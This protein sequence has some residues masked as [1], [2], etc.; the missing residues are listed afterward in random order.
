MDTLIVDLDV[1]PRY[2]WK[3][4]LKNLEILR[5]TVL[6]ITLA[7]N[8]PDYLLDTMIPNFIKEEIIGIAE[9]LSIKPRIILKFNIII[10]LFIKTK[11]YI[12]RGSIHVITIE[13]FNLQ[14]HKVNFFK[15]KRL[16]YSTYTIPGFVGLLNVVNKE[17]TLHTNCDI[18]DSRSYMFTLTHFIPFKLREIF[19]EY[20]TSFI[21]S[22][23]SAKY[24]TGYILTFTYKKLT[25]IITPDRVTYVGNWYYTTSNLTL[26]FD[27]KNLQE[28]SEIVKEKLSDFSVILISKGFILKEVK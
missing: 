16:C 22:L 21:S 13:D 1:S 11:C 23:R 10:S 20:N 8:V 15:N 6:S 5:R 14:F 12:H 9:L 7:N 24:N 3:F 19:D 4:S 26:P 18:T 27:N 28:I 17:L 2:R 25:H